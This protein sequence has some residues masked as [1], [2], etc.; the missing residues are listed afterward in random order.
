MY[1]QV[2][3]IKMR[4]RFNTERLNRRLMDGRIARSLGVVTEGE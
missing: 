3:D 1:P 4:L 2:Y